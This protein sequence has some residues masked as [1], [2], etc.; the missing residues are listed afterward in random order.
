MGKPLE[1][2]RKME[3]YPSWLCQVIAI[4]AMAQSKVRGF[5]QL[6]NG[7]FFHS[8]V[9]VYQRVDSQCLSP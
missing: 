8:Y 9:T 6:E 7:G 2:H 5:S 3:V 4:E 1:N